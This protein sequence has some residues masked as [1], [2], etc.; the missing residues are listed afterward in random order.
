[1][2]QQVVINGRKAHDAPGDGANALLALGVGKLDLPD[3]HAI[4]KLQ[5]V[6]DPML[7]FRSKHALFL[8]Q[9]LFFRNQC[10]HL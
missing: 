5:I 3:Q 6:P 2:T 4:D 1:V 7:Q 9:P 10:L 8:K